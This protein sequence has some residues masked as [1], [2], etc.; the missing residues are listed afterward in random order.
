[1]S[2]DGTDFLQS[3]SNQ[4]LRSFEWP[5]GYAD[6]VLRARKI[7]FGE[8]PINDFDLRKHVSRGC[9]TSRM[10]NRL[11]LV[12]N[13]DVVGFNVAVHDSD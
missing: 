13:H 10:C 4:Q 3:V 1:M 7:E 9:A 8:T 6:I 12:I 5:S 2:G 11:A